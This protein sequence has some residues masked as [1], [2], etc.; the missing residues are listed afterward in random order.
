MDKAQQANWNNDPVK[1][2]V[3]EQAVKNTDPHGKPS[4]NPKTVQHQALDDPDKLKESGKDIGL[5]NAPTVSINPTSG[6]QLA[7]NSPEGDDIEIIDEPNRYLNLDDKKQQDF[8]YPFNDLEI[9]QGFF[10]PV[11]KGSTTDALMGKLHRDIAMFREATGECEKDIN[12]DDV[13]ESVVIQTKKRKDGVIQLDGAGKPIVGANQ[14]NR[15]KLIYT[16]N[17]IVRAV[18]KDD[19]IYEGQKAETDGILVIRVV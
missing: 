15:P 2:P 19:E 4:D 7:D 5:V 8:K 18:V 9:G 13:W 6:T 10:V 16:S 14:T 11:E 1:Q 3:D 17:F 12:G